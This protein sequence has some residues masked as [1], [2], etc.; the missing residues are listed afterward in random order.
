MDSD[1]SRILEIKEE[2]RFKSWVLSLLAAIFLINYLEVFHLVLNINQALGYAY[3]AV[4]M[5]VVFF[6]M[7]VAYHYTKIFRATSF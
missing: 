3:F 5:A 6:V 2:H 4:I 7:L 1:I